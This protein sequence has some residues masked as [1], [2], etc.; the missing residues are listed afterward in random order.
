MIE[1]ESF[2]TWLENNTSYT[3]RVIGNIVS[4]FKRADSILPWFDDEVYQFR[5][6]QEE[7]Y[8]ALSVSVRSQI[9][10]SVKLYFLFYFSKTNTERDK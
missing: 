3:S 8:K 7:C 10:K 2:K 4:R 9:K 6:E 1:L 5:L